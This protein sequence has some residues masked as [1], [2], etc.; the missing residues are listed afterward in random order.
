MIYYLSDQPPFCLGSP[1]TEAHAG[2]KT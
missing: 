1:N 2:Q